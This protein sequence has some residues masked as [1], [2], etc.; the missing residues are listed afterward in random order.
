[1]KG[2]VALPVGSLKVSV[3]RGSAPLPL[4]L[5]ANQKAL[6]RALPLGDLR[7]TTQCVAIKLQLHRLSQVALLAGPRLAWGGLCLLLA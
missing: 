7:P 3:D 4:P 2:Q 6:G 5:P 1:M